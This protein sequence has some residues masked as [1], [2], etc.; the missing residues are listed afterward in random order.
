M[1]NLDNKE[2]EFAEILKYVTRTAR[3]NH[4]MIT[5]EQ[6]VMSFSQL[7]ISKNTISVSMRSRSLQT[8]SPKKKPII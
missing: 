3:E 5:K 6:G 2:K 7:P 8:I 1:G 4:N